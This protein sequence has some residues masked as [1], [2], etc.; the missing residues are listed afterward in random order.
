MIKSLFNKIKRSISHDVASLVLGSISFNKQ[1]K[2]NLDNL[3][4][5]TAQPSIEVIKKKVGVKTLF[6]VELKVFSQMGEDGIIQYLVSNIEISSKRFIEFGVEDYSESNTRF[7]L[8]NNNWEGLIMDGSEENM[9]KVYSNDYAW[10]HSLIAKQAFVTKENINHLLSE[11]GFTGNIG[12][13]SIDIDG[14]DYWIW[15]AIT[16]VEP[17]I[18]ICEYNSVFGSRRSITIPYKNNFYLL[19]H[20]YS[21]LYFGASLKALC[22]LAN[23]KGY[24]FV[25]SNSAGSNAFF[26]KKEK[27]DRL[28]KFSAEDGYVISKFRSSR[29]EKGELTFLSG[30]D[31]ENLIKGLDV[32][33]IETNEIEKF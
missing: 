33:N 13:L 20:H 30:Q 12:L 1:E 32:F 4:I 10:K 7:L 26:V 31:R 5:L 6:D 29:N 3:L 25:G 23:K 17:D 11:N 19:N 8:M 16:V 27:A 14:N 18:I 2:I 22:H 24:V 28:V 15:D 21:N 9:K